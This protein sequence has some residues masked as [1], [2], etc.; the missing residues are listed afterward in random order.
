MI[1][2]VR[3]CH[4][5]VCQEGKGLF[6]EQVDSEFSQGQILGACHVVVDATALSWPSATTGLRR[7]G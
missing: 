4:S 6:G 7:L 3:R 5:E 2:V 1:A